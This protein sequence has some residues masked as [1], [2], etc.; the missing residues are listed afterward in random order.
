MWIAVQFFRGS[1]KE[2][3]SWIDAKLKEYNVPKE[4]FAFDAT[5]V[6]YYLTSYTNGIPITPNRRVIQEVDEYGNAVT[7][8]ECFNMR[9]QL[10]YKMKVML[11]K[12]DIACSLDKN[13]VI[14]YGKNG[15]TR[16]L[17][18]VLY[19]EIN[20]FT[21]TSKNKKIYARSKDEYK[22]K[23]KSSPNL[24][25]ALVYSAIFHLDARP[26]KQ[27]LPQIPDDAYNGL[28]RYF[29]GSEKK[30]YI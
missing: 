2:L 14:P 22:A 9:S 15:Q 1:S 6:G 13:M 17:I 19:D 28:G 11:E 18:D 4:H 12:G 24:M 7:L 25:D 30:I 8:E 3:V 27:P 20:V 5:G 26:K 21:F 23:Y 10:T 29:S 16:R